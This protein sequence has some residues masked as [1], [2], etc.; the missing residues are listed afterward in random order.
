ME[1]FSNGVGH[2]LQE[3]DPT[4]L[5]EVLVEFW[6]RNERVVKGI[7]RVGDE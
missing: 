7:K 5:A 4:Q 1:V 3:D 6:R 2:N